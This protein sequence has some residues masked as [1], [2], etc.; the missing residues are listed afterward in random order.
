MRVVGQPVAHH[1]FIEKVKGSILYAADWKLPGMLYGRVVRA[2]VSSAR[3]VS[4]HTEKAR[5]L[6]G[7]AAVLTGEDVPSNRLVEKASGGPGELLVAMP[8]LARDRLRYAGEPIA[9]V[10]AE[11]QQLADDAADL[12]QV[13]YEELPGIFDPEAALLPGAPLVHDDGNVLTSWHIQRG[14][15]QAALAAADVVIEGEYRTQH[16]EHASLE[17]ESGVGWIENDVV[18]LRVATQII[19]HATDIAEMLRLPANKVRLIAAYMGGSFGS[20]EGMTVEPYLALLVWKTRR[21]VHMVWSRQ[22]SILAST[23]GHPFIMRYRTGA[24]ND[25][26]IVAQDVDLIG[27]AGAYPYKSARVMFYGAALACGPYLTPNVSVRS[28]AV[29]TNNVPTSAFRGFGAR[30]VTLGYESQMDRL[31]ETL[32]MDKADLRRRNFLHKG[33]VIP[34]G[35]TLDTAVAVG[36][37]LERALARLG[38]PSAPSGPS[39][40]VGRGFA[41]NMHPY[42]R[43]VWFGDSASAWLSIQADGTLLI[44]SGLS[45]V[46]G[47]QAASLCQIASEILG[48]PLERISV[49][50][51][52]T[53]LTP[54]AGGTFATRQLLMSGNAVMQAALKLRGLVA[55]VAAEALGCPVAGIVFEDGR[56]KAAGKSASG[57]APEEGISLGE[58]VRLCG[59]RSVDPTTLYVFHPD[60]E[61]RGFQPESGQLVSFP[62]Y[63]YGTHAAEV[64]VDLET[65]EVEVLKYASCHDVGRAINP[66]RV[67]GQM[68]GGAMQGLG[69]ALMEEIVFDEGKIASSLLANYLVPTSDDMPDVM[70]D[71]VESGEGKGPMNARGI[72]EA[73]IGNA[74]PTIANAVAD[75]IGF[76]P[77]QLPITPERVLA[78]LDAADGTFASG[79]VSTVPG[80]PWQQTSGGTATHLQAGIGS[81]E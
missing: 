13:E 34:T 62:D 57:G 53:A 16:V 48:V 67:E 58:L 24:T 4:I 59:A 19:E 28:R 47:G 68:Q 71:I 32:G 29:F 35:E 54:P 49:Y 64:E 8:V 63:T 9:L 12:V 46:G 5:A 74:A 15:V 38:D 66:L 2:T 65:G 45:D 81:R 21:P 50:I 17:T 39:K 51:G 7:V 75:A 55:P 61:S 69:Y 40:R 44:R 79:S 76:R 80:P 6:R 42:G 27:D 31:A 52:D 56:V 18:T 3:I 14:D 22:E 77:T 73:V 70:V 23:K 37:T 26:R 78:L 43:T 10:A 30:Q 36:E 72:G 20:K 33:D 25:G 60:A 1:D 41:C 11:T